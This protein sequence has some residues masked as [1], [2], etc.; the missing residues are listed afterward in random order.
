MIVI[1]STTWIF[2]KKREKGVYTLPPLH[3]HHDEARLHRLKVLLR[4]CVVQQV[5]GRVDP[6]HTSSHYC[7][8]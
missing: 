5:D 2:K 3:L 1:P 4:S 7:E 8:Q 6:E